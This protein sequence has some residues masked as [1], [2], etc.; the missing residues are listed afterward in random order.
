[1]SA[2]AIYDR[3]MIRM[4]VFDEQLDAS[5]LTDEEIFEMQDTIFELVAAKKTPFDTWETLQ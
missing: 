4:A 2:I 1:M 5:F 3:E